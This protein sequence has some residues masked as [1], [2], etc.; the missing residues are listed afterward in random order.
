MVDATFG[1]RID[2]REVAEF[3]AAIEHNEI[4]APPAGAVGR[5]D[6]FVLAIA[7]K[8]NATIISN[9]SYQE[10][11]AEYPWL[12]DEGRLD[13]RQAGAPRRLGVRPPCA[14]PRS[15]Q[16]PG[17]A[18]RQARSGN[19]RAER[20][21]AVTKAS[22]EALQPM[23]VPAAPP[24]GARLPARAVVGRAAAAEPVAQD[25]CAGGPG[26]CPPARRAASVGV[27]P[28]APTCRRRPSR[29]WSTTLLPFLAFVEHHPV[30]SVVEA[31]VESYAS[32]G[33]YVTIGD[34]RGYVPLRL[35]AEPAPR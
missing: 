8:V 7:H 4:V 1:H 29:R 13:R 27:R 34:A 32:H 10:F 14:G 17:H 33:A 16:P 28:R 25:R 21:A 15:A 12:F 11:H 2:P 6:A 5:G 30:G 3:D 24:P 26:Q 22:K 9:D 18:R 23:P 35:M 19:G 31:V 20:P